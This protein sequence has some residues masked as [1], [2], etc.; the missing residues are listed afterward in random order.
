MANEFL[1]EK[2]EARGYGRLNGARGLQNP[3]YVTSLR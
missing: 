3:D 2:L 1:H